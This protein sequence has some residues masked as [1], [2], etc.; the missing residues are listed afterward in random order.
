LIEVKLGGEKLINDGVAA[1][2]E[3]AETIDTTRM[4]K[5]SFTMVL[6]AVGQY[7][8]QRQDGVFVVP[9]GCLRD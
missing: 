9:I 3:L 5:P 4:P 6:T 8:Y 2:K 1:L 7:A